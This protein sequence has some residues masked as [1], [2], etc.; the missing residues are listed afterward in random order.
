VSGAVRWSG[1][2]KLVSVGGQVIGGPLISA[3]D[4]A[5]APAGENAAYLTKHGGVGIWSPRSGRKPLLPDGWGATSLAWSSD[6]SLAIGRAVCHGA[7]GRPTHTE[8]WVRRGRAVHPVIGPLVGDTMPMVFAWSDGRVLWWRYPD[9][10]SLAA[11][12]VALYANEKRISS[13]LMYEDYVSVC[14]SHLAVAAGIDRYAM[15][16]KRILFD[17]RDVSRDRSRSWV[18]PSCDLRGTLIAAA[19]VN[20]TPPRIGRE[21]RA[22]WQLLPTRTQLTHPPAGRTDEDPRLLPDGSILFIRTRSVSK[23]L[24]LYGIGTIELLRGGRLTALG[25]ASKAGNY[26]G[27]YDWSDLVAVAP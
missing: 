18:S 10:A 20:T 4:P 17:G 5:W 24:E 22:I 21:H 16:G 6:G 23:P 27:H 12:G 9:S 7:C 11:D 19:S 15:H 8:I 1:D 14:G 13:G 3:S 25:T 2:G 26:Y